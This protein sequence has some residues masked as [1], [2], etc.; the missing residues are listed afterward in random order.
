[1]R[2]LIMSTLAIGMA[3]S[4]LVP[5]VSI[6]RYGNHFVREPNIIILGCEITLF[7]FILGY[8]I[9]CMAYSIRRLARKIANGNGG[10]KNRRCYTS[11]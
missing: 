4:W 10:S 7:L 2:L 6:L 5:F 9:Y 1:M 11:L 8:S 3:L